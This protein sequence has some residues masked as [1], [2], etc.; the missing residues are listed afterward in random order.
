MRRVRAFRLRWEHLH[1]VSL[2]TV[3]L[4]A[5]ATFF[6]LG[7]VLRLALGPVSLGPF[8]DKLRTAVAN[9]VPGLSV[10]Y[11]DA[12]VEWSRDEGR[13]NLI[14]VGARVFD[15]RHHIIAQAPKAE[16]GVA[17]GPFIRGT[18]QI[19]RIA[20]VGVQLTLVRDKRGALHLGLERNQTSGDV[21]E[22]I[23]DAL[24][25][26]GNGE[27]SLKRFAVSKARLAFYDEGTGLFLVAPQ[28]AIDVADE[29]A[30]G[31]T[32]LVANV[33][34]SVEVTGRPARVVAKI[35]LPE[36]NEPLTGALS[37]T[38]LELAALAQNAKTFEFLRPFDLRTDLSASFVVEHGTELQSADL[39][40]SAAGTV[41]GFGSPLTIK[42]LRVVGRYDGRTNRL[43]IDDADLAGETAAAHAQGVAD[44]T[45]AGD[46]ALTSARVD[47]TADKIAF[48]MPS[49]FQQ[50]VTL[51]GVALQGTYT[52][53]DRSFAIQRLVLTG[54][55]VAGTLAG[56]VVIAQN[57]SPAIELNGTI[58]SLSVRDLV[59]YWPLRAGEGAR[60]WIAG[61]MPAGRVGPVAIA[62]NIKAGDLDRPA[63]PEEA[64]KLTVP[65]RDASVSYL[66]GMTLLTHANGT[67]LMTGD[68][69]KMQLTSGRVGAIAVKSGT[70]T[71]PELHKHGTIGDIAFALQGQLRDLLTVLDEK[72]LQYP[73]KFHIKPAET[74]G[75]ASVDA[76]FRVP[77]VKGVGV[78]RIPIKVK[79]V[80]NGLA[81][82]LG[83]K[84]LSNGNVTFDVDN[85]HLHAAGSLNY[86]RTP[87]EV[88]WN[89]LF[90]SK[91]GV[92]TNLTAKGTLDEEARNALKLHLSDLLS[93]PVGIVA[94]L[95]G[96]RGTIRDAR[97]TVDLTPATLSWDPISFKKAPGSG[98]SAQVSAHLDATGNIET[99]D[100]SLSGSGLM[101]Q[102]TLLMAQGTL[103]FTPEG[104]IAHAE[105]PTFRAG[106]QNDFSLSLSQTATRGFDIS[107]RGHSADGSAFGKRQ[108]NSGGSA[109]ESNTPYHV[110]ARLERFALAEGTVLAPFSL[111]ASAVGSRIQTLSLSTG[112]SKA[113][114]V[115]ASITPAPDGRKLLV[116]A[117]DAGLLLKG[118]F[119]L[120]DIS[121]GR[122]TLNAKMP[123]FEAAKGGTDYAGTLI[124]RDFR[125][126]NQPF[127]SR[128]F[129]AG[130]LGGL[131][132]LM[133]GQGIVIDKLETPFAVRNDVI[134]IHDGHAS[135]PS[136]GL[137]GDGYID[138]HA[139]RMEL[140]GAVAPIY[141]LNSV[142]GALPIVGNML[143]SKQGEGIFGVTYDASGSVDE[144]KITVNPLSL[145]TPGILR[146][147]FE[148]NV[149]T[150]P[151]QQSDKT[152][153]PRPTSH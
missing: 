111:D 113:D 50:T 54:S 21:L 120:H 15:P 59:R 70:V 38:G 116:N 32:H 87:L 128:L 18:I 134:E 110:V 112:M 30:A 72:P 34:A 74:A 108:T 40:I 39:G 98:A 102:G 95:S 8:S 90:N 141:G 45:F 105:F 27:S 46:A 96:S 65:V 80:V 57:Q 86:G 13:V 148:G 121:G 153:A 10:D 143:V 137:S 63:L 83:E 127:F 75:A 84:R 36:G 136:V 67:G 100:V 151:Q 104:G 29:T 5:I 42:N 115:T 69:F 78:D 109:Q 114:S 53:A 126:E 37:V 122:L 55:P 33:D 81:L 89:E 149:P 2:A 92:T 146:R 82:S 77:M 7:V 49:A 135:G 58:E 150:A 130:S 3:A 44:L 85:S 124:I 16:I 76:D 14:I 145:L 17:A 62:A 119:G 125:I 22:R 99:A 6:V 107:L 20:L 41:G 133:R 79:A 9:T 129:S 31:R 118:V 61:N 94:Q 91:S 93:G 139:N 142:L 56:K 68:T 25:K 101:A 73:T 132:D 71:I 147:I 26:S 64:L 52:T 66:K 117:T 138:R 106:P 60:A 35:T 123:P 97:V 24:K 43:L 23:L 140:R 152:A 19:Q 12:A 51:G 131:L 48:T 1:H 47:L 28:A 88:D 103:N 11:D 144:P 4:I